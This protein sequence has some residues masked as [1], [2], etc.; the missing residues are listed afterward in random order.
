MPYTIQIDDKA[1]ATNSLGI[2]L[3]DEAIKVLIANGDLDKDKLASAIIKAKD[4]LFELNKDND[5]DLLKMRL[6][7]VAHTLQGRYLKL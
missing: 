4:D 2:L 3:L 6:F 1:E 5:D 7:M